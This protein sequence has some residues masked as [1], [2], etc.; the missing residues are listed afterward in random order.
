MGLPVKMQ[1]AINFCGLGKVL[2]AA[3]CAGLNKAPRHPRYFYDMLD[4]E[5]RD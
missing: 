3:V 2:K 1:F 5:V 4:D